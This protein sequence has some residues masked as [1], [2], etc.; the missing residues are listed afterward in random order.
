MDNILLCLPAPRREFARELVTRRHVC[1]GLRPPLFPPRL[2][3][4]RG[5]GRSVVPRREGSVTGRN[6]AA[7]LLLHCLARFACCLLLGGFKSSHGYALR[8]AASRFVL[9]IVSCSMK[10][11]CMMKPSDGIVSRESWQR[12]RIA[13][14]SRTRGVTSKYTVLSLGPSG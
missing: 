8:A 2:L 9:P 4:F 3:R 12:T 1:G 14:P 6:I 7:G 10:S 11:A 5:H 13:E